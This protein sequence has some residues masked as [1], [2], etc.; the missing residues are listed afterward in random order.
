[1]KNE[2]KRNPKIILSIIALCLI[3]FLLGAAIVSSAPVSQTHIIS[4]GKYPAAPDYTIWSNDDGTYYAKDAY[5]VLAFT[6]AEPGALV[7]SAIQAGGVSIEFTTGTFEFTTSIIANKSVS[8]YGQGYNQ[9]ILEL[10]ANLPYFIYVSHPHVHISDLYLEGNEHT[11][12][13]IFMN[14]Y[15][16]D[17]LGVLRSV[18]KGN[19]ITHFFN[20]SIWLDGEPADTKIIDNR[21]LENHYGILIN[22][23]S[24]NEI[25]NNEIGATISGP[26]LSLSSSA[27]NI[28]SQNFIYMAG[29]N[30]SSGSYTAAYAGIQTSAARYEQI[31]NNRLND[32][33]GEGIQLFNSNYTT[34]TGGYI[35]YNNRDLDTRAGIG[36]SGAFSVYNNIGHITFNEA[37]GPTQ[38]YGIREFN[39]ADWNSI[40]GCNAWNMVA[41]GI[42]I[43]G[44]NTEVAN[45]F[46]GTTWIS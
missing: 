38:D 28:I 4:A 23:A 1:M 39:S 45:S 27:H 19:Y 30:Y 31:S 40:T 11:A 21:V 46:N 7:N 16:V 5:G 14:G 44:A 8:I 25:S 3:S 33:G 41:A 10:N 29:Y 22:S 37:A 15:D 43:S 9:T 17:T 36:I 13:A 26:C 2:G 20:Y 6:G 18:I 12:T 42:V 35:S 32:N 24:D 34:I